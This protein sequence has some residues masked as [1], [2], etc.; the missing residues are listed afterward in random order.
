V[1]APTGPT[2]NPYSV[3]DTDY[4]RLKNK[5][6]NWKNFTGYD[7]P[8]QYIPSFE[9]SFRGRP[10]ASFEVTG[11]ITVGDEIRIKYTDWNDPNQT[12][13]IDFF[14]LDANPSIPSGNASGLSFSSLGTKK[15]IAKAISIAINN[16]QQYTG[17]YQIFSSIS[18]GPSVYIFSRTDSETW[19]KLKFSIFSLFIDR[20]ILTNKPY[21][22]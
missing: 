2:S 21:F 11:T 8:F 6:V 14:T 10:C 22:F 16:I 15:E 18:K 20:A 7:S 4:L 1:Y 12:S 19:N 5:N 9:S 13:F 3:I 17:E